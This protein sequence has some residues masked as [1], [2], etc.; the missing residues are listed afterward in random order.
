VRE[1]RCVCCCDSMTAMT[2]TR[3]G[4]G[5]PAAKTMMIFAV[6]WTVVALLRIWDDLMIPWATLSMFH[7]VFDF[8]VFPP[9]VVAYV[10]RYVRQ[11]A[12]EKAAQ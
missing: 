5:R 6:L 3:E 2:Y 4:T 1:R 12:R 7:K 8:F 11:R 9:L 10:V